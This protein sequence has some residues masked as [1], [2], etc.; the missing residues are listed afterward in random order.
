M[1]AALKVFFSAVGD[2][3]FS[4]IGYMFCNLVTSVGV[5]IIPLLAITF[6]APLGID[7]FSLAVFALLLMCLTGAP[8]ML[9]LVHTTS[10][11]LRYKE[12]PEISLLLQR[13]REDMWQA[14]K[15]AAV[16]VTGSVIIFGSVIFYFF[17]GQT[18]S[19]PLAIIA[20]VAAWTWLGMLIFMAPLILRATQGV[21]LALRNSA[22]V[23][24]HYPFF[25]GTLVILLAI[26]FV[27]SC[28]I[29]PLW[30]LATLSL[31]S[32]VA[33]RALQ[34]ALIQEGIIPAPT[35]PQ[36]EWER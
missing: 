1:T 32:V 21:R 29:F 34:W 27:I 12:R 33:N 20:A 3:W 11:A 15:L 13:T 24:L 5:L 2:L 19:L 25:A 6:L 9:G 10:D 8:L 16:Q 22:V 7:P 30:P 28:L 4:L 26:V 36:D 35:P 23:V 17:L 14:W 18:W 31:Y